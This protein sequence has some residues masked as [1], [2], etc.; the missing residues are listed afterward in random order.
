MSRRVVAVVFVLML[1]MSMATLTGC[2]AKSGK[3]LVG[4]FMPTKEQPIWAAYGSRLE[5]G[6][7]EAGY[8][9]T[10][11]FAED[12]AERQISQIENAIT[13]GA[14][15]LVIAA[16]DSFALS[17]VCKKAK[18]AGITVLSCD[19]LIMNTKN[20]DYYVT[21]DMIR[22]GELQGEAIE[23]ALDLKSGK[24]PFNMEI[25]S[26]SPD[27]NNCVPFYEGFMKVIKPYIDNK[28]LVVKSGQIDLS[29]TGTLKWDSATAQ[30][31][32]DNIL[33]AYYTDDKVD[34]VHCMADCLSLGVISSLSSFGYGKGDLKFPVVTG[35]DS[36]LTA[37]KNIIEGKQTMTVFLDPKMITD[38][39]LKVVKA[40]ESGEKITPDTTYNNDVFDVPTVLY[41][42]VLIDKDNYT[43]RVDRGF[44]TK[45]DLGLK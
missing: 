28:Q 25:F 31:R 38:R 10:L 34:A 4:L 39:M 21:F 16:V 26:G 7:K 5:E 22:L 6:F 29:V 3:Q 23:K 35:Q 43:L 9:V 36:E 40:I 12:V 41:D 42:P 19:R 20:V 13:K 45:E 24:G 44:Y 11:E 37:I 8:D 17:D 14:K 27:D 1:V 2:G 18:D 15:Y 33:G 30:S 32:M